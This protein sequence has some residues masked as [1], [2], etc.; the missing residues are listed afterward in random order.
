MLASAI[1]AAS[2]NDVTLLEKNGKV[3]K[4]LYI[5]GKGRCNV[6]N[7]CAPSEFLENVV[8]NP[9]FLMSA[10]YSFPPEALMRIIEEEGVPLT[11]ERGDRVFPSS[12]KSSDIIRAL[13]QFCARNKVKIQLNCTVFSIFKRE[14]VFHI[15]TSEGEYTADRVII[16]T[17]GVSYPL[18]GSTGDGYTFA[19]SFGHSLV[20]PKPSLCA[21]ILKEN[22]IKELEGLSLK[23]VT[24]SVFSGDKIAA[25]EF[26]E[27]LFTSNGVSGPIILTLSAYINKLIDGGK[28]LVLS[29]DLKPALSLEQLDNRIINDFKLNTNK[30]FKNSLNDL[31]PRKLIPVIVAL[32]DITPETKVNV[33]SAEKRKNLAFL[34][35]NLNFNVRSLDKIDAAV[36]T[37]GGI[38]V[39][40]VNPKTM[41]SKL[42][43]GLYFAGEVLDVD[44]LTGGYNL[45]IA[46]STAYAAAKAA[47]S[48]I[49]SNA[50]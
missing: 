37:S 27:M 18:T 33:I 43:S 48:N 40:E 36:I 42:V 7:Y 3:G 14:N 41:E 2:D 8:T 4:K 22:Y 30:E 47:G 46:F 24:A 16:A 29:I 28:K 31:L 38:S 34:L 15:K 21:L 17:G 12:G 44:A 13:Q 9:K 5:T 10:V 35:K 6:T 19:K 45:Q 1:A 39:K 23:N 20:K 49:A 32:S 50:E 25:S 11:V 26:G